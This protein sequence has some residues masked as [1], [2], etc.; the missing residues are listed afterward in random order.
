MRKIKT[1]LPTKTR[2]KGLKRVE[3]QVKKA[4]A[5]ATE[6]GPFRLSHLKEMGIII[7][8]RAV[9]RRERERKEH[10]SRNSDEEYNY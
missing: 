9:A 4:K 8:G 6:F 5:K 3:E 1:S 7:G 10:K 2:E